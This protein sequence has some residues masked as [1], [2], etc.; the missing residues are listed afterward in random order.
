MKIRAERRLFWFLKDGAEID[1]SERSNIDMF[2][3]QILSHGRAD[4]I[5]KLLHTIGYH[6]FIESFQRI[7]NFLPKEVKK[8]WEESL[9]DIDRNSEKD[10]SSN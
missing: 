10:S 2:V 1:L 3:Q 9:G 7:K 4:D 8:F 6:E 5:K